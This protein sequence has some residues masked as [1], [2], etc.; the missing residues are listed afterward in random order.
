MSVCVCIRVC[1]LTGGAVVEEGGQVPAAG[2]PGVGLAQLVKEGVAAGLQG[3]E[4]RG[5]GILQQAGA[6]RDGLRGRPRL[7]H[8]EP[9]DT[10][11]HATRLAS[12]YE[13]SITLRG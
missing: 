4:A 9:G 5:G 7:E 8:L 10:R 11:S 13:A 1:V 2:Q 6:Q 3:G 12:R